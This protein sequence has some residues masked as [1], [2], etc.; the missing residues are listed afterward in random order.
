MDREIYFKVKAELEDAL[1]DICKKY[2][3]E[4]NDKQFLITDVYRK[5]HKTWDEEE[6]AKGMFCDFLNND[7]NLESFIKDNGIKSI[8]S[9]EDCIKNISTSDLASYG[10]DFYEDSVSVWDND[11]EENAVGNLGVILEKIKEYDLLKDWDMVTGENVNSYKA[12]RIAE[13]SLVEDA[14]GC[15][16]RD[17]IDKIVTPYKDKIKKI[18]KDVEKNKGFEK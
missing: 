1:F 18:I 3:V 12:L 6:V 4:D 9:F 2:N 7:D 5:Y 15:L 8:D 10:L 17:E 14:F 11:I 13:S 16:K